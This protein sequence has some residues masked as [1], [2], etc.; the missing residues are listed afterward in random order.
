MPEMQRGNMTLEGLIFHKDAFTLTVP[1]LTDEE[2]TELAAGLI[3]RM[4]RAYI[5]YNPGYPPPIIFRCVDELF[6]GDGDGI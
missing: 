4:P 6:L 5:E 2:I 3:N 1:P